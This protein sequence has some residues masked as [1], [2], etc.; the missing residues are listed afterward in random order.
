MPQD[1]AALRFLGGREPF[2][3]QNWEVMESAALPGPGAAETGSCLRSEGPRGIVTG[4]TSQTGPACLPP[5]PRGS[6]SSLSDCEQRRVPQQSENMGGFR[7]RPEVTCKPL[8]W[9]LSR[10]PGDQE[11]LGR[12]AGHPLSG[13]WG[14]EGLDKQTAEASCFHP[15]VQSLPPNWSPSRGQM[16]QGL[17]PWDRERERLAG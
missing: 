5:G 15:T 17:R 14:H 7:W 1:E 3:R 9:T 4:G 10:C 8:S 6:L 12:G 13:P 16:S 11:P 2:R